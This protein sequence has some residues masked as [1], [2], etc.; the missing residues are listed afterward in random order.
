M[1]RADKGSVVILLS[2]CPR[3]RAF[4]DLGFHCHLDLGISPDYTPILFLLKLASNG[5]AAPPSATPTIFFPITKSG[6]PSFAHFAKGGQQTDC[7]I[8]ERKKRVR[9]RVGY[10][11]AN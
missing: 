1:A 8:G 6:A 9:R 11:P 4:R 2:G 3:S 5:R 10:P 7:A